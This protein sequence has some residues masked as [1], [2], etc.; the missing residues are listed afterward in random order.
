MLKTR[1]G[2]NCKASRTSEKAEFA[3]SSS[4]LEQSQGLVGER[5][6]NLRLGIGTSR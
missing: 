5:S 1:P 2:P 6:V 4:L 3:A